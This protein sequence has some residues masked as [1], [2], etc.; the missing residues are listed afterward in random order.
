MHGWEI[1]AYILKGKLKG[2][3]KFRRPNSRW[4]NMQINIVKKSDVRQR[5]GLKW[6]RTGDSCRLL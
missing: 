6:F 1:N 3:R 4:G 5:T 2:K